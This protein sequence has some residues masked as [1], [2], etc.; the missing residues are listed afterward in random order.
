MSAGVVGFIDWI[1]QFTNC[2]AAMERRVVLYQCYFAIHEKEDK[3]VFCV[4]SVHRTE[5]V[6]DKSDNLVLQWTNM[7]KLEF[8]KLI[9]YKIEI[10]ILK[11]LNQDKGSKLILRTQ[12]CK[13]KMVD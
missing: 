13:I 8:K 10:N 11:Y 6:E 1:N 12:Y 9:K 3:L 7:N 5:P 2:C 4:H